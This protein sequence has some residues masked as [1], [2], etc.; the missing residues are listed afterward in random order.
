MC[1]R[2]QI[3][4]VRDREHDLD[5]GREAAHVFHLS[6]LAHLRSPRCPSCRLPA[7]RSASVVMTRA[8]GVWRDGSLDAQDADS[9][10]DPGEV[11][12]NEE[13]EEGGEEEAEIE[14][15]AG[16]AEFVHPLVFYHKDAVAFIELDEL[17]VGEVA[18]V[19]DNGH[20][21]S[22]QAAPPPRRPLHRR[23]PRRHA[24]RRPAHPLVSPHRPAHAPARFA[25]LIP[26]ANPNARPNPGRTRPRTERV[27]ERVS[28]ALRRCSCDLCDGDARPSC[29]HCGVRLHDGDDWGPDVRVIAPGEFE[30]CYGTILCGPCREEVRRRWRICS[31]GLLPCNSF[32]PPPRPPPLAPH[33]LPSE[34]IVPPFPSLPPFP[35]RPPPAGHATSQAENATPECSDEESG[36]DQEDGGGAEAEDGGG[37]EA[38][39]GGEAD[40][41]SRQAGGGDGA[42]ASYDASEPSEEAKGGE[43]GVGARCARG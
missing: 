13:E 34:P 37:A 23:R 12:G 26:A 32:L 11:E 38:E 1:A 31:G 36:E 6:C 30:D 39:D 14:G 15:G 41:E 27:Y 9:D 16:D 25:P 18:L 24:V 8:R 43:V 33:C 28:G 29:Q 19:L 40:E 22:G 4:G 2:S 20:G 21:Q 42:D 5:C 10:S 35:S 17:D 7:A 3:W